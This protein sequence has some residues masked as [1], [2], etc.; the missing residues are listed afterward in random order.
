MFSLTDDLESL[1]HINNEIVNLDEG[2]V[3][4]LI[5]GFVPKEYDRCCSPFRIDNT[6]NCEFRYG[7]NGKLMF[8]DYGNNKYPYMDCYKAIQ[9]YFKLPDYASSINYIKK[10]NFET[11]PESVIKRK[12]V[13]TNPP[14]ILILPRPFYLM[15]KLY[16]E[17]YNIEKQQLIE[18]KVYPLLLFK[19]KNTRRGDLVIQPKKI[20]YAYTE[21]IKDRKKIYLPNEKSRF[22]TNCKENDIGGYSFLPEK[23]DKIIITKS[24]KDYRVLKNLGF[25]TIWFMNEGMFPE[26]WI[27]KDIGKVSINFII[28]FDNDRAGITAAI[29]LNK[30]LKNLGFRSRYIHLPEILI[31]ENITDPADFTKYK[32]QKELKEWLK[33]KKVL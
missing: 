18:D 10:C 13:N 32:S 12:S 33:L 17:Q 29:K 20:G 22:F 31:T 25:V 6:P 23:A 27:L 16:W 5:F 1:G 28:F 9:V 30:K 4:S 19:M 2:R 7:R 15:D 21:F 8:F 14:E 26:D 11:L 3:F 24:Y